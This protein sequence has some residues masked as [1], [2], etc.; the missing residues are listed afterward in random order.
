MERN[1]EDVEIVVPQANSQCMFISKSTISFAKGRS[2]I[3]E[4]VIEDMLP[5]STVKSLAFKMLVNSSYIFGPQVNA[6]QRDIPVC[7][8]K[9]TFS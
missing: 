2:F 3:S 7:G 5:F 1:D 4:Y 6:Y 8:R 9:S